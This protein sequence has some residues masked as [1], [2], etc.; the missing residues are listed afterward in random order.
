MTY[1]HIK[2]SMHVYADAWDNKG[3]LTVVMN[4]RTVTQELTREQIAAIKQIIA[5]EGIEVRA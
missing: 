1:A 5:D 3:E 4:G 2:L